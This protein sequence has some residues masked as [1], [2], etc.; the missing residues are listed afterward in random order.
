MTFQVRYLIGVPRNIKSLEG[1]LIEI[2]LTQ[3]QVALIDDE[4]WDLVKGYKWFAFKMCNTYYAATS[5]HGG[6]RPRTL[7]MHRLIM[8]A[9]YEQRVDHRNRNGWDN[10]KDNLRFS[11][12]SENAMNKVSSK[13][14]SMYKGVCWDRGKWKASIAINGVNFHIG[15]FNSEE[16][17]A[18][19]YD[20][21]AKEMFGE[22]VLLNFKG[23]LNP[24][25]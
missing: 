1:K 8:G 17:A 16:V 5:Q 6:K 12:V 23:S 9:N 19:A 24:E 2:P 18:R 14:N 22:F 11:S 20:E 3:G 21:K 25:V 7:F 13:G 4:D 15:R 10:R